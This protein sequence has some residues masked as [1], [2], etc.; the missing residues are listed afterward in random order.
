MSFVT[1]ITNDLIYEYYFIKIHKKYSKSLSCYRSSINDKKSHDID[2]H[3][4][5]NFHH[6]VR[7]LISDIVSEEKR[8]SKNISAVILHSLSERSLKR[9]TQ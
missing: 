7:N 5:H 4:N 9:L 6:E 1:K 2:L 3:F 8:N